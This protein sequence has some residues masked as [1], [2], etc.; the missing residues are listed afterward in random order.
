[1][2]TEHTPPIPLADRLNTTL[3]SALT[4]GALSWL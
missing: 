2:T 4:A 1:M 3:N